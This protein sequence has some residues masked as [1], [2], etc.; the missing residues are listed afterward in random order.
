LG[1]LSTIIF[2]VNRKKKSAGGNTNN[3]T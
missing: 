2:L 1:A 3:V